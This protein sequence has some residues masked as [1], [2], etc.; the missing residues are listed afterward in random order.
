MGDLPSPR[1][2]P[3]SPFTH[4]GVD[5][6]GPFLITPFVGKGQKARKN[7]IALFIC[8]VT[9]AIHLELVDDYSSA[10]F[11]SAFRRFAGRRGLP[12]KLYSDNGTNFHGA[13]RELQNAFEALMKD[14]SLQADLANDRIEWHFIPSAAPHFGGLWEA[15]VKSLKSHLKRVAGSRTLS[16]AEFATLLCQIEACLNSRPI[17]ALSDDPNDLSALTPGH[18][19]R[20]TYG[21]RT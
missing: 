19:N 21:V 2:N 4:T 6:A 17:A 9:K 20:S 8:L 15:G 10:G 5:Y 14:A 7:W 18:F 13:D 1:V 3:S 11:I 16:Q 12:K